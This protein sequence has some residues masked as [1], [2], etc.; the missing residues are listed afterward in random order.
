[1]VKSKAS[2]WHY[3]LNY[4]QVLKNGWTIKIYINNTDST[5]KIIDNNVYNIQIAKGETLI[6]GFAY[7]TNSNKKS[8]ENAGLENIRLEIQNWKN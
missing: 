2:Q 6:G 1:M 8:F 4:E 7:N 3:G 5:W